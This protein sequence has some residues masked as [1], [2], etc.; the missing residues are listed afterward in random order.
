MR[1]N[2]A[3]CVASEFAFNAIGIVRHVFEFPWQ[4]GLVPVQTQLGVEN[5]NLTLL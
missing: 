3:V 2:S 4:K 5:Q 1:K